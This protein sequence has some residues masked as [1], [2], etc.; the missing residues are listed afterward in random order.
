MTD[1]YNQVAEDIYEDA[2]DHF[3]TT[4]DLNYFSS[5]YPNT[6]ID[7]IVSQMKIIAGDE[8][9]CSIDAPMPCFLK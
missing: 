7:F 4:N 6:S 3:R 5:F 1:E 8:M 2:K 9:Q